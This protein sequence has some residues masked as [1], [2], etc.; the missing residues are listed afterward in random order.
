M[1]MRKLIFLLIFPITTIFFLRLTV[2]A[3]NDPQQQLPSLL[4]EAA[5]GEQES[6]D[7]EDQSS[8]LIDEGEDL[9]LVEVEDDPGQSRRRF[10]PTEEIS[11]ELGVSFPV[12]I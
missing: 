11:Q 12:D 8:E 1:N 5:E 7:G 10:I 3:E 9:I 6:T 4:T 2:A